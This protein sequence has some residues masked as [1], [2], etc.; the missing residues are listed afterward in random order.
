M[1]LSEFVTQ[2]KTDLKNI[3]SIYKG[4][5]I[6]ELSL[7]N[8]VRNS[9]NVY[10]NSIYVDANNTNQSVKLLIPLQVL[11][12]AKQSGHIINENVSVD[13]TIDTIQLDRNSTILIK[14]S[15][16][17][18]SGVSEQ[19]LFIKNLTKYCNE[20]KLFSRIKK[21]L[22]S[23]VKKIA[24]ISTTNTNTLDDIITNLDFTKDTYSFKVNN[25]SEAIA[26][27]INICQN[28]DY[29]LILL[30]RGGHE[31]K[32]MNIYSDI[33]VLNAIHNSNTHVGVA[34]GHEVDTPFVYKIADSTYSTPTNFAQVINELNTLKINSLVNTR[35]NIVHY[36]GKIKNKILS[37][38]DNCKW[39]NINTI[40]HKLN[41]SLLINTEKINYHTS[42]VLHAK[43]DELNK[44][45]YNINHA[46]SKFLHTN[47][48]QVGNLLS[49]I[50]NNTSSMLKDIQTNFLLCN[51]KINTNSNKLINTH[52]LILDSLY[53]NI[54]TI[55]DKTIQNDELKFKTIFSTANRSIDLSFNNIQTKLVKLNNNSNSLSNM[56]IEKMNNDLLNTNNNIQSILGKLE[57]NIT[58]KKNKTT[59]VILVAT[60]VVVVILL[61]IIFVKII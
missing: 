2:L 54:N 18:E 28:D 39:N 44:L 32:N 37:Q 53:D 13:V 17:I 30:Y 60:L 47:E 3:E 29:D 20:N 50:N 19:E 15:K 25:T 4:L 61:A 16:I 59:K 38:L 52:S 31:D 27:Q 35:N 6:T 26:E 46:T 45:D 48:I 14:I 41:G 49:N 55:S 5:V 33:P 23:L 9:Q 8:F 7:P 1:T 10:S 34:L 43:S 21:S 36:I 22:P 57:L 40:T 11:S 56:L 24:L 51:E 58:N 42:K 12:I